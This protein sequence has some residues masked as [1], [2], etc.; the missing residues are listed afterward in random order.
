MRR[1]TKRRENLNLPISSTLSADFA[2]KGRDDM[3]SPEHNQN[4][5]EKEK[6][7][8]ENQQ[9]KSITKRKGVCKFFLNGSCKHGISG[10]QC[11]FLHP[12]LCKKFS[13][14]M[15]PTNHED[16]TKERSVNFFILPCALIL[17]GIVNALMQIAPSNI[18]N[19]LLGNLKPLNVRIQRLKK[20]TMTVSHYKNLQKYSKIFIPQTK[21]FWNLS[22]C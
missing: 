10:K 11:N 18:S 20:P 22:I 1:E 7:Q 17:C 19:E 13:L 21:D 16:A 15:E 5:N 12:K 9:P 14:N 4:Q 6:N 3:K 2:K 8:N